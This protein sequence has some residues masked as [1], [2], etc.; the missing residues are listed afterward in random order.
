MIKIVCVL[1]FKVGQQST[2]NFLNI[3]FRVKSIL[4]FHIFDI[5]FRLVSPE[6]QRAKGY[7]QAFFKIT[8]STSL[9]GQIKVYKLGYIVFQKTD[10]FVPNAIN[11]IAI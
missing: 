7:F 9:T 10:L 1:Y 6:T 3:S 5:K 4:L 2:G 11:N 8:L